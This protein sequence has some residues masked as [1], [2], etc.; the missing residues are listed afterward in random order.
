MDIEALNKI[1]KDWFSEQPPIP[2][3]VVVTVVIDCGITTIRLN[4]HIDTVMQDFFIQSNFEEAGVAQNVAS[5]IIH[6]L[7]YKF[8]S[9]NNN[10]GFH[11]T[12]SFDS[13]TVSEFLKQYSKIEILRLDNFGDKSLREL[14]KMLKFFG[15]PEFE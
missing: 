9:S 2:L 3:G 8:T 12:I 13:T 14:N 10:R 15:Y 11:P 7:Q 1:V 5:R 6:I 4:K